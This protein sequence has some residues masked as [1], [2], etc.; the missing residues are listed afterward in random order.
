MNERLS[1]RANKK[2]YSRVGISF[3]FKGYVLI[4]VIRSTQQI[5]YTDLEIPVSYTHLDVYKRQLVQQ[6][7]YSN[8]KESSF[9]LGSTE[10]YALVRDSLNFGL[11]TGINHNGSRKLTIDYNDNGD[12]NLTTYANGATIEYTYDYRELQSVELRC[13]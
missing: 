6:T 8:G 11:V 7:N 12:V 10:S 5:I 4:S 13:V 9:N 3:H 2:R 1:P